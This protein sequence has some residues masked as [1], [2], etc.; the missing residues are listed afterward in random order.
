VGG[1][2]GGRAGGRAGVWVCVGVCLCVG[3]GVGVG[4]GALTLSR[5]AAELTTHTQSITYCAYQF[6]LAALT[7]PVPGGPCHSV[8]IYSVCGERVG[9][10]GAACC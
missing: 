7:W 8:I 3:V 4:G 5:G 9:G 2:A 6:A 1:Q 10:R